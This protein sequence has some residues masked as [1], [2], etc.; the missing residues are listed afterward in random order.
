MTVR[1]DLEGKQKRNRVLGKSGAKL[2]S[3]G[4]HMTAQR[5]L[6]GCSPSPR[7]SSGGTAPFLP[8]PGVLM[9]T[10]LPAEGRKIQSLHGL[11]LPYVI[12]RCP[13]DLPPLHLDF[14]GRGE[15]RQGVRD[16]Q[17]LHGWRR[18]ER[19]KRY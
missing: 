17:G 9:G 13:C 2:L 3:C 18:L 4:G 12:S 6:Q 15:N 7:G 5:S 11:S 14:R 19:G 16:R 1:K 8:S 10:P